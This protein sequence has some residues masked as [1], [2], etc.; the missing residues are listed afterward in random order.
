MYVEN[1][2]FFENKQISSISG[3]FWL[4]S[5]ACS[6]CLLIFAF[7]DLWACLLIEIMTFITLA[8]FKTLTV[9]LPYEFWFSCQI[10][11]Y[12]FSVFLQIKVKN[13]FF[14]KCRLLKPLFVSSIVFIP[15]NT[16]DKFN[17]KNNFLYY[18]NYFFVLF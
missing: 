12:N 16:I 1:C 7:S 11:R 3:N 18:W 8:V 17:K 4:F 10:Q 5:R 14:N 9:M 6:L 15:R 13:F 2:L